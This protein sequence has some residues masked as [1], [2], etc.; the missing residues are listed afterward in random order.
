[1]DLHPLG[2]VRVLHICSHDAHVGPYRWNLDRAVV[3]LGT[4]CLSVRLSH[5]EFTDDLEHQIPALIAHVSGIQ[6]IRELSVHVEPSV[7]VTVPFMP[8]SIRLPA[9]RCVH[10]SPRYGDALLFHDEALRMVDV[11][12]QGVITLRGH[13][14][15]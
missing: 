13:S 9:V 4:R 12:P 8:D 14:G 3:G 5:V 1:M 6:E 15:R 10:D 2:M 7:G 11:I